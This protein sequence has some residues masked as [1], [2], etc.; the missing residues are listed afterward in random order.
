MLAPQHYNNEVSTLYLIAERRNWCSYL[1]DIVKRLERRHKKGQLHEDI[2]KTVFV[3]DLWDSEMKQIPMKKIN[4]E[5]EIPK[6]YMDSRGWS[7]DL[8]DVVKILELY[9]NGHTN[10]LGKIKLQIAIIS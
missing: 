4:Y 5:N 2:H 6:N 9:Q 1:F 8:K 7:E 3:M 10:L